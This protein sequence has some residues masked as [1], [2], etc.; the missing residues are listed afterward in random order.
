M[1][2]DMGSLQQAAG[3]LAVA[4][5]VSLPW[6]TSV[7][8]ILIVVWLVAVL[9]TLAVAD[10]RRELLTA[11]GGLPVLLWL[12]AAFGMLW[13]DV[14]WPERIGGLGGFHRLLA[15]PFLLVQFRRSRCGPCA[16]YGLL[17]SASVMFALSWL[18]AL[19][20]SWAFTHVPFFGAHV[21]AFGVPPQDYILQI[22]I[23]LICALGL[24]GAAC[25]AWRQARLR[26]VAPLP[27]LS[28]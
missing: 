21:K 14:P 2:V 4:V 12:L 17:I 3:C 13:A 7:S 23:F 28:A 1:T 27:C 18:Y 9:P 16:S 19:F 6:S 8:I 10:V 5:A 15:I 24:I 20:P 11:A 25:E 26:T 22:G